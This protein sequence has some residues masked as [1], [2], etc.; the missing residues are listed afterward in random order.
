M[1]K[2]IRMKQ[3]VAAAMAVLVATSTFSMPVAANE[4]ANVRA[5][6]TNVNVTEGAVLEDGVYSIPV[7]MWHATKDQASSGNGALQQTAKLI[8][9]N[10]EAQLVVTYLPMISMGKTTYVSE[11]NY[12]TDMV[13]A[14]DGSI[15]SFNTVASTVLSTYDT[16]DEY[17]AADSKDPT[18]AGKAYPKDQLI[19]VELGQEEVY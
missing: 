14:E 9:K 18:V 15:A 19:P 4:V 7:K 1:R 5:I 11:L 13:F 16:V 8:I 3:T 2:N 6:V 17:N 12:L 10:G